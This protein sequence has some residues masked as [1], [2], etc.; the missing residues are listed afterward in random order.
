MMRI[1]KLINNNY[2]KLTPNDREI[3]TYILNNQEACK[4]MTCEQLADRCHVS[5]T[6]LLRFC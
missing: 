2:E 1:D 3:F 4:A 6:T 5:R